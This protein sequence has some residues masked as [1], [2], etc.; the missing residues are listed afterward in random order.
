MTTYKKQHRKKYVKRAIPRKKSG[1]SKISRT[2]KKVVSRM[3]ETKIQDLSSGVNLASYNGTN[4]DT[5]NTI[6]LMPYPSFL[7]IVQGTGQGDRIGDRVTISSLVMRMI[8][9]P[10]VY[11]ATTN[12]APVPQMIKLF[13]VNG[14]LNSLYNIRPTQALTVQFFQDGNSSTAPTGDLFDMIT[15]PNTD[16]WNVYATKTIKLGNSAYT[17]TGSSAV[18]QYQQNNDYKLNHLIKWNITK[19]IPKVL[20]WNDTGGSMTSRGLFLMILIANA[21]GTTS[22]VGTTPCV[23]D[24]QLTV[25]YKDM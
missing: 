19:Y 2:I 24:Y 12:P 18:A 23:M 1:V 9:T 17:G 25:K 14:K 10:K 3:S 5:T 21:D 4:W 15:E 16:L 13:L 7:S 20:H 8:F 6:P 22:A 11:N